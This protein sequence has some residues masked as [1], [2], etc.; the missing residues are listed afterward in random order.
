MT[1][2]EQSVHAVQLLKQAVLAYLSSHP[3]GAN[4]AEIAENLN[5]RSDFEGN[6]KDYLSYSILGLL[7]GERK[8]RHE[9]VGSRRLYFVNEAT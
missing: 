9:K 5:L 6:Q 1:P 8:V 2:R 3:D 7:I 4:N